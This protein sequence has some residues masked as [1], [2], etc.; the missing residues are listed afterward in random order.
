MRKDRTETEKPIK[1][2]SQENGC[3][4]CHVSCVLR[5]RVLLEGQRQTQLLHKA[6][7]RTNKNPSPPSP[8]THTLRPTP[9]HT[10]PYT[11]ATPSTPHTHTQHK[12]NPSHRPSVCVRIGKFA[13]LLPSLEE[14]A[15]SQTPP[16]SNI[17]SMGPVTAKAG[18]QT[19]IAS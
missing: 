6:R 10:H 17:D 1:K 15:V 13:R 7:N 18:Q 11:H 2:N 12:H 5:V 8:P 4:S 19:S 16:D 14:V 9:T 3:V